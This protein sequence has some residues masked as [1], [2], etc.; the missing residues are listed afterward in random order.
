MGRRV[1]PP[2]CLHTH[3]PIVRPEDTY[4]K[5]GYTLRCSD[6]QHRLSFT[7]HVWR[8]FPVNSAESIARARI[9][10]GMSPAI[11]HGVQRVLAMTAAAAGSPITCCGARNETDVLSVR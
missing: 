8:R 2:L 6:G 7:Q 4:R 10:A 1:G 11:E 3:C 9:Y 5:H